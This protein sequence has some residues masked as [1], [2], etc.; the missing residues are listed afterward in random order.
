MLEMW[1]VL[2]W[3]WKIQ[4]QPVVFGDTQMHEDTIVTANTLVGK[5]YFS[6]GS[7]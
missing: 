5:K 6:H 2:T 1:N 3:Y 7:V 4:I